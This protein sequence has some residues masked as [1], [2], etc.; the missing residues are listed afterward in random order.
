MAGNCKPSS[1]YHNNRW[2]TNHPEAPRPQL[3]PAK[4]ATMRKRKSKLKRFGF[5]G[6]A[7]LS[8]AIFFGIQQGCSM[9]NPSPSWLVGTL[10]LSAVTILI[11]LGIWLWDYTARRGWVIRFAL[12]GLALL[13][14]IVASYQPIKRQYLAEHVSQNKLPSEPVASTVAPIPTRPTAILNEGKDEDNSY[15]DIHGYGG[16]DAIRNG[17][18]SHSKHNMY[19][20]ITAEPTRPN[21]ENRPKVKPVPKPPS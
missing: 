18:N 19:K 20:N 13:I 8:A 1:G 11:V 6:L 3:K 2:Y 12:S 17:P 21:N 4:Q 16:A 14:M 9:L 15:S 5:A 10:W 7:F